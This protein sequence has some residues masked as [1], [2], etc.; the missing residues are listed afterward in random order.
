MMQISHAVQ[1]TKQLAQ[2]F[3]R[4]GFSFLAKFQFHS[5]IEWMV[6]R[7]P[8]CGSAGK[9]FI[10]NTGD[11]GSIPGLGRSSGEG[12]GYL[13]LYPGLENSM[14]CIVHRGRKEPDTTEQ[15]S[16]SYIPCPMTLTNTQPPRLSTSPSTWYICYIPLTFTNKLSQKVHTFHQASLWVLY[17]LWVWIN[18]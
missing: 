10:C 15:L 1:C 14:D 6:Q 11:L 5:K 7:V 18:L 2:E 13:L 17:I 8:L 16:L 9:E 4:N 12:K 3:F